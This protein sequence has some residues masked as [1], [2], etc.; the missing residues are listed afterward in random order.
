MSVCSYQLPPGDEIRSAVELV[1]R[2]PTIHGEPKIGFLFLLSA[3][4][5]FGV[6]LR[7]HPSEIAGAQGRDQRAGFRVLDA[8]V[9]HRLIVYLRTERGLWVIR[10]RH[11]A[12]VAR[13]RIA[14]GSIE[15]PQQ[16]LPFMSPE[17]CSEASGDPVVA[18]SAAV[19]Q[20]SGCVNADV[21]QHP[22][23]LKPQNFREESFSASE[24]TSETSYRGLS[25][26][27]TAAADVAQHPQ[28]RNLRPMDLEVEEQRR[29][30][31]WSG[32]EHQSNQD[33]EALTRRIQQDVG[34]GLHYTPAS[35]VARALLCR[36][37]TKSEVREVI[38]YVT[39]G[40]RDGKLRAAPWG[41]FVGIMQNVFDK[42]GLYWPGY[43]NREQV[44]ASKRI[45]A[46]TVHA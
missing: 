11:P 41:V 13:E 15:D 9:K 20:A 8:L 42:K 35:R 30:A 31:A 27:K 44:R 39:K 1:M 24:E 14:D 23:S 5:G 2:W 18:T 4:G 46:E 7:V 38:E 6:E 28:R 36:K 21:A 10:L 17:A 3:A 45:S 34:G 26:E 37:L 40:G 12:H 22:H 29:A 19:H 25:S 43:A 32:M 33:V 16:L